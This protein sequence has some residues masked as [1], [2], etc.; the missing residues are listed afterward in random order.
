MKSRIV[1]CLLVLAL[2]FASVGNAFAQGSGILNFGLSG[3][4]DT[5]DPHKTSGTLTFQ[6]LK[7]FYDTLIEPDTT[8]KLVPAL[9]ES[10]T[11]TA[12][13]LTWTFKLRQGVVFHNG[14]AFSSKDVKATFERIKAKDAAYA[15]AQGARLL[16]QKTQMVASV[17][18]VAYCDKW[19]FELSAVFLRK[20]IVMEYDERI[21][22]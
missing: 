2:V 14:Q 17:T 22:Q 21:I 15:V 1:L 5:L 3:N 13:G 7:S 10:W 19:E 12:D 6:V 16:P 18:P 9:A 20:T 11:V 8:G 4:P